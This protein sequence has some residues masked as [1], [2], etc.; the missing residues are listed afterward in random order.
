LSAVAYMAGFSLR[1][2]GNESGRSPL[3]SFSVAGAGVA[4][5]RSFTAFTQRGCALAVEGSGPIFEDRAVNVVRR[6]SAGRWAVAA[7][8]GPVRALGM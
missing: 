6:D 2:P 3:Q 4:V 1:W 8:R 7:L 5:R